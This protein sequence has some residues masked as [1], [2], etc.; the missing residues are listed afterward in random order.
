[1]LPSISELG[2]YGTFVDNGSSFL[3]QSLTA[4]DIVSPILNNYGGYLVRTKPLG[5]D[6]GGV[7]TGYSV[8]NSIVLE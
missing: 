8:L 3:S 2:I 1:M 4:S 6:E 5:V 7:A